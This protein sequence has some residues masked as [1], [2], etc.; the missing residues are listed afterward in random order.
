ML[1]RREPE[2]ELSPHDFEKLIERIITENE[3]FG[4][5]N[6]GCVFRIPQKDGT[7][8]YIRLRI[9]F[10]N[11]TQVGLLED[12]TAMTEG[13]AAH[14]ARARLRYADRPLQPQGVQPHL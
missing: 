6:G 9:A 12:V 7:V 1:G 5:S 2:G 8:R 3:N 14:R 11:Q 10:E 13:T 4:L